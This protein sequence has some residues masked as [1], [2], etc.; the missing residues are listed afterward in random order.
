MIDPSKVS[1]I[2]REAME[3]ILLPARKNLMSLNIEDKG[4]GELVT[5]I[6]LECQKFLQ[7]QL[8]EILPDCSFL[9]E[10]FLEKS[11]INLHNLAAH[12]F[13]WIVDPL[14]NTAGY[15]KNELSFAIQIAL[16]I[17]GTVRGA[18][19]GIPNNIQGG[20]LSCMV[21]NA[22]FDGPILI[23]E[24]PNKFIKQSHKRRLLG[25]VGKKYA[26]AQFL[27]NLKKHSTEIGETIA[28][29]S[30]GYDMIN[31][32]EG[33]IDYMIYNRTL[34]WDFA[35]TLFLGASAGIC[36][37]RFDGAAVKLDQNSAGLICARTKSEWLNIYEKVVSPS[38]DEFKL[39]PIISNDFN[40]TV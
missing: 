40:V 22:Y 14:D 13:L 27:D 29:R 25:I 19:I 24:K 1:K 17:D 18:W 20:E 37:R 6:D 23:N 12:N 33:K 34:P 8:Y 35:A 26:E 7:I 30:A 16:V 11:D 38:F 31:L 39:T 15:T 32:I 36:A 5:S 28:P 9:G 10:E 2:I 4:A 3:H 21:Y